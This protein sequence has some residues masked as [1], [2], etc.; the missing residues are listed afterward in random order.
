MATLLS[1]NS[2]LRSFGVITGFDTLA[3]ETSNLASSVQALNSS[4]LGSVLNES[5]A[6]IQSIN[7]TVNAEFSIG[8]L[9]ENLTGLRDQIVQDVSAAKTDLDAITGG[10]VENSF[11]DLVFACATAEGVKA[12]IDTVASP[13]EGQLTTILQNVVPTQ[14]AN[15][16]SSL[17]Q[18]TF[19]DF[20]VDLNT[21]V[22]SF[23]STF[24][25]LLGS[26][27]GNPLQDII[28]QDDATPIN[29]IE[30]LGVG[31]DIAGDVFILLQN[32][33]TSQAV[34]QIVELT[35]RASAE[36]EVLLGNIPISLEDQIQRRNVSSSSTGVYDVSDKNNE[37]NGA[38]TP[39]DF[40]DVIATQEQLTVE[41][42]KCP[43]EITE[44]VFFGH[45]MTENQILTSAEIH[46]SYIADGNDGIPFHYV[47]LPNGNIQ[48]GRPLART[49]TYSNTHSEY[50]IGVVIPHVVGTAATVKQGQSVRQLIESFYTVWPGG[51]IF[52]AQL[53]TGDSDIRVGVS[54]NNYLA[55]FKKVNYGSAARSFSSRQLIS[56]AQGN[57]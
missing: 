51:Q 54:V 40:F 43:R 13:T 44:V 9:T 39:I 33:Q 12:A 4:S 53:D 18:K 35:G 11:N 24:N 5:I 3:A 23:S 7:T 14:Y 20:S 10:A 30:N 15:Q 55:S 56:A 1:I 31:A 41:M 46:E 34:Q 27:T 32:K 50:S 52:D 28:L 21:A 17:A 26:V 6:G 49:G 2:K 22:S 37:W 25:N 48:R 47:V 8:L 38:S 16:V 45:E 42:L 19:S 29:L 57:V 36:V